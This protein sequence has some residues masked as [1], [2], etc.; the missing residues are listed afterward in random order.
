VSHS[1]TLSKE[2]VRI[3]TAVAIAAQ[4]VAYVVTGV[5]DL[6]ST[7]QVSVVAVVGLI[8][9]AARKFVYSEATVDRAIAKQALAPQIKG[10]AGAV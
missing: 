10:D 9:M 4:V 2:A 6:N 7:G 1:F 8:G 5:L 3:F